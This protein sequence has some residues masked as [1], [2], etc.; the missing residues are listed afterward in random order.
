M[1]QEFFT[2][3]HHPCDADQ[4]ESS[5]WSINVLRYRVSGFKP[6]RWVLDSGA[7]TAL[8]KYGKHRMT[9]HAYAAQIMHWKRYGTLL[10]AVCQDWMCEK[11]ML[12]RTG[13]TV[14]D[15]Q[16]LTIENYDA[17]LGCGTG[18]Y[19]MPVLQGYEPWEYVEHLL[20]Y[21]DRL[22]Y[23]AWVGVGSVCKRNGK[24]DEILAILNAILAVRPDLRIHGFGLKIKAISDPRV[25]ALLYTAD[26]MAAS[27]A[28]RMDGNGNDPERAK[29]Y[30]ARV[31]Q[32][33][34]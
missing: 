30:A 33:I 32:L 24:P 12:A 23:G 20:M 21:G 15:H 19:I 6:K 13:L 2:G 22:A 16:R 1:L 31:N 28:G 25:N 17:L 10:A 5:F 34:A 4:F 3:W 18:V 8:M 27:Y 11:H 29:A 14:K 7:F 9:V 26:S